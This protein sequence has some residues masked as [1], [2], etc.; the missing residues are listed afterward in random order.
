MKIS[1]DCIYYTKSTTPS[2]DNKI[3]LWRLCQEVNW[4]ITYPWYPKYFLDFEILLLWKIIDV[5]WP[6]WKPV[7]SREKNNS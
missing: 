6:D 5:N 4:N 2:Y 1:K 3:L 7:L